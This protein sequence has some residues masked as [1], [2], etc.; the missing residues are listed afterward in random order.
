MES[1]SV[2]P[3]TV[4]VVLRLKIFGF[5]STFDIRHSTFFLRSLGFLLL[6]FVFTGC[7]SHD[8][9]ISPDYALAP[10]DAAGRG[11][12][13]KPL[14]YK[15]RTV[16][17]SVSAGSE[18]SFQNGIFVFASP[19]P[20]DSSS[21]AFGD[22][23]QLYAIRGEGPAVL[24]SER[25]YGQ[26]MD[27]SWE[28]KQFDGETG[29]INVQFVCGGGSTNVTQVT[30]LATWVDIDRWL[31]EAKGASIEKVTPLAT[32]R[33]LQFKS[34]GA[35]SSTKAAQSLDGLRGP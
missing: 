21:Y 22:S 15:G 1:P 29:G 10:S 2:V 4:E 25:I 33:L 12:P 32:Y 28:V 13:G 34:P 16:W 8:I 6:I 30:R 11:F 24:I 19:V 17:P 20:D 14:L 3:Y 31:L 35:D 18:K 27:R 26:P 9:Q 7:G 23:L 5:R